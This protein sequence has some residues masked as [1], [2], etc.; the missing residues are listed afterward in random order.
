[1]FKPA[2]SGASRHQPIDTTRLWLF[3]LGLKFE[4]RTGILTRQDI[5]MVGQMTQ[6]AG[7]YSMWVC[8]GMR[9]GMLNMTSWANKQEAVSKRH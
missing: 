7:S 2:P 1:M 6:F 4:D 8:Q 5:F 9:Q 3:H